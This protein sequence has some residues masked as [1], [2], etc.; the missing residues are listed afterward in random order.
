MNQTIAQ[1]SDYLYME[2][3][4]AF[5]LPPVTPLPTPTP[6]PRPTVTPTP[7]PP[8]RL[9][10]PAIGVNTAVEEIYP[11]VKENAVSDPEYV[12]D[13]PSFAVGHYH[14][15]G[16]PTQGTNIVLSG[17]N[18]VQGSV[19][20]QLSKVEVGDRVILFDAEKAFPYTVEKKEIIPY[21]G[22]EQKAEAELKTYSAP[23]TQEQ[24]TLI[25]CWPYSSNTH[26][27]VVI[28]TPLSKD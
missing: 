12:W 8:V 23:T 1:R 21:V 3:A 26:R 18:N 4:L 11:V 27:V 17:H 28:A 9:S 6:T 10:I 22:N 25:S 5:Q 14:T 15:S 20:R 2:S 7:L 13:V 16:R 24:L 19:F